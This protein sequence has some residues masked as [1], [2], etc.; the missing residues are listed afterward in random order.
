MGLQPLPN[1]RD[2]IPIERFVKTVRHIGDMRCR[3][4]VV[5][6]PKRVIRR[7]RPNVAYVE[8]PASDLLIL[9]DAYPFN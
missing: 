2:A 7:Q 5:Q 4:Y 8:G 6:R 1:I 3:K 9:Q